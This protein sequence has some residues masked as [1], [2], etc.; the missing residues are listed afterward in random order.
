MGAVAL[1]RSRRGIRLLCPDGESGPS[2]HGARR[3]PRTDLERREGPNRPRGDVRRARPVVLSRLLPDLGARRRESVMP[4]DLQPTLGGELLGLRP[5]RP[6]DFHVLYAVASDPLIWEQHPNND[7]YKE[8]VFKGFFQEAMKSGGALIATD[9]R[10]GQVIGSS[11]FHGYDS[12]KGEIEIGWTFLARTH[13]GGTTNAEMKRL[14]LRHA[15]RF[16]NSVVFLVGPQNMRS[17]RAMEKIGGVRAGSR[18]DAAGR[19]SFVYRVAA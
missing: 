18:R 12:E 2:R 13:W 8:D 19:E 1:Q 4:F 3:V 17:Q 14:M 7:R 10:D 5:L 9:A 11:R 6:E 15:F 16:V